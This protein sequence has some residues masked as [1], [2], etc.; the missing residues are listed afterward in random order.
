MQPRVLVTYHTSEGQSAKIAERVATVLRERDLAVDVYP[1]EAA[2]PPNGYAAVVVG[3]SIHAVHHSRALVNYVKTHA[4]DLNARPS[5][6]FQVSLTSA[7][8][9]EAHTATAHGMVHELLDATGFDPDLVGLFAGALVYSQY[10]W[11]KRRVMRAIVRKEGGDTDMSR[12]HE[13]TD[14][15]AVDAFGRDIAALVASRRES[16]A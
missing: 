7:N 13:Y 3:D 10:G 14:W 1:V 8:P 2:P 6:L 16:R 4:R 12:D 5:A 15:E 9:D 11:L